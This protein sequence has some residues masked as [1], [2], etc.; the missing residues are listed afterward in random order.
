MTEACTALQRYRMETTRD[1]WLGRRLRFGARRTHHGRGPGLAQTSEGEHNL[2]CTASTAWATRIFSDAIQAKVVEV[3]KIGVV[4]TVNDV[5]G[6]IDTV[7]TADQLCESAGKRYAEGYACG[8]RA[9][10]MWP[11]AEV[12]ANWTACGFAM[13]RR[14]RPTAHG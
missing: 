1:S 11:P 7:R 6:A 14:P 10:Y 13:W 12:Y 4:F 3:A 2:A 9:M 5:D 8:A